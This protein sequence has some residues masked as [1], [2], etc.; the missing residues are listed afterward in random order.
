MN[1]DKIQ[2]QNYI[3]VYNSAKGAL[4]IDLKFLE[5]EGIEIKFASD[6]K[7]MIDM[8]H[9]R[10]AAAVITFCNSERSNE[11]DF[12]RYI[13]RQHPHT[14]RIYLTESLEQE[15]IESAINKAHVNYLL[16]LPLNTLKLQ[17]IVN[18]ACKRYRYLKKPARRLNDL[19]DLTAGLLEDINK[20]RNEAGT[21]ALTGLFNRRSFDQIL[22]RGIS[23]F[24]EKNLKFTL[25]M[26]DLDDFKKLNDTYGHSAGDEVLRVF[27]RNLFDNMRLEDSAF[28]YGGEE[29]AI[30]AN[31]DKSQDIKNFVN[32]IR[33][34]FKKVKIPYENNYLSITFSAGFARM[35]S[36]FDRDILISAADK[37]LYQA[38]KSGKDCVVDF[39]DL[40]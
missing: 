26:I 24:S 33:E 8:M 39:D 19:T 25:V 13:M 21:D 10:E 20:Y 40:E 32:R 18:K 7:T 31:G 23:L 37:A 28:R 5:E 4:N 14:Q 1:K 16:K 38:K 27:G 35:R 12:L 6:K 30:I 29:F 15:L 17:E 34:G 11:I 2:N 3:L 36:I 22:D 9:Q